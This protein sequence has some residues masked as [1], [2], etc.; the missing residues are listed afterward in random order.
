MDFSTEV[1]SQRYCKPSHRVLACNQ[2][3]AERL[4]NAPEREIQ[5]TP[6]PLSDLPEF[7]PEATQVEN[8]P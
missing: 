5:L 2:R 7:D 3:K 1:Y 4:R 6:K 8:S